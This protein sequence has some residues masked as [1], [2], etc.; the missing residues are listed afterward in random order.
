MFL[1][2]QQPDL[3]EMERKKQRI[4]ELQMK[5]KVEL[6]KKRLKMEDARAKKEEQK[7]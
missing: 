7:R 3:S 6:E 2:R 5:R 4:L 1:P